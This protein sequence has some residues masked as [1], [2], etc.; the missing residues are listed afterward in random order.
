MKVQKNH[1]DYDFLQ[2]TRFIRITIILPTSIEC[3]LQREKV[4]TCVF[5]GIWG[6]KGV[7]QPILMNRANLYEYIYPP[8]NYEHFL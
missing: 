8:H 2:L 4:A 3:N 6:I 5:W 7:F 1:F